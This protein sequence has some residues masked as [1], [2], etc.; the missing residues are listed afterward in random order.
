MHDRE[1]KRS[2][3]ICCAGSVGRKLACWHAETPS[4]LLSCIEGAA[5]SRLSGGSML[6]SRNASDH[7]QLQHR[8]P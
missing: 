4:F 2:M 1:T 8:Q 7:V 3:Q 5:L 6:H